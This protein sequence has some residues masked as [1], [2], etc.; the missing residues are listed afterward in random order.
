MPCIYQN[1]PAHRQTLRGWGGTLDEG[2]D[3]TKESVCFLPSRSQVDAVDS[4]GLMSSVVFFC[5]FVVFCV[6]V[7]ICLGFIS[8]ALPCHAG[9]VFLG[10]VAHLGHAR[11]LHVSQVPGCAAH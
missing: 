1:H 7:A 4:L 2:Q 9:F 3:T 10:R 11:W 5:L 8:T 6:C